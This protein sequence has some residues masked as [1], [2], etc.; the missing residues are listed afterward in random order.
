MERQG[1]NHQRRDGEAGSVLIAASNARD[2]QALLRTAHAI[3]RA[4]GGQ[5]RVLTVTRTGDRPSWLV[6]PEIYKDIPIETVT[7]AGKNTSTVILAETRRYDPDMLILGANSPLKQGR[8]LLGRTLDPVIQAAAC[9]IIVQR[10]ETAPDLRRVLIPAA[11]GPNA[12]RAL[13]MARILAPQAKITTLYVADRKLGQAEVLVG[14]ARLDL[15]IGGLEPQD[16]AAIEA[17]IVQAT[18]PV[19]GILEETPGH[20]LLILGAGHEGIIDRFL[21]GDIPQAILD[22][23]T[24]P[25]M[26]FRRRLT[27]LTSF[28]RRLWGRIFGLL[29]TLTLQEQADVQK[30]VRRGSLPS[31]DFFVML[32]L[33]AVLA[34]LG[35]L[36]NEPM[37]IIGAMIVAP[38]MNAIIG[39]GL[40]IVLG[41]P[42][43]FWRA[44]ATT[45][46]G[47]VLAVSM[48]FIVGRIVPG[49]ETTEQIVA[50]S[51][52]SIL[53]LAV[54]LTAGTAAAYA[55]SRKNVSAALAGVAVATSLTPPLV[56]IGIGLA[57]GSPSIAGRAAL[58]FL[59]NLVAIVAT[60]GLVFLWMGFRPQP[61]DRDRA[62][63]QRRGFSTLGILLVLITLP[64]AI[65]TRQSI[66]N[67]QFER[68]IDAAIRAEVQ[69]I[70]GGEVVS[71]DYART[72]T[73]T[74]SLDLTMRVAYTIS[75]DE[76]R[77]LQERIATRIKLPVAL[78]LSMVPAKRLEA[79]VPPTPT[80]TPTTRPTGVPTEPP[81]P[82]P[83]A[84]AAPTSTATPTATST[85]TPTPTSTPLPT[86]TPTPTPWILTVVNVGSAGL[87]VRYAP[88][89][90]TM[91]RIAEGSAVVVLQGPVQ[92]GDVIWYQ[93]NAIAT[94]LQGWVSGEFLAP[95]P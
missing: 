44:T 72:G 73:D 33:A 45:L 9:D 27:S 36:M 29:P 5:I 3:A 12:P 56:N 68:N 88:D 17:R 1:P 77:D 7:R 39:V 57:F 65:F 47:I 61:G 67:V 11:G 69:E 86:N 19:D 18:S 82:T 15:M 20:D 32:T 58:I 79:F 6:V 55:T 23:S 34:A 84:T 95:G 52:P 51:S 78:S 14:R 63:T 35:L 74:L 2:L 30:V 91:G 25:V 81:S 75:Y 22:Q 37:V 21:F 92:S 70:P 38:L 59:A 49:A 8:Y 66:Q 54:A 24:I 13:I 90:Q 10:G 76:A 83:T 16:R 62:T 94:H 89:G 41:D 48:G 28:W 87:R 40:S 43:F 80:L 4:Q 53:H 42:R 64:L 71:W 31:S 93:V 60:S 26:V 50:L 85:M 46:R